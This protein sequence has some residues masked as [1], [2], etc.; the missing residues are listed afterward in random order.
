MIKRNL[1]LRSLDGQRNN[2]MEL[3][4]A[5]LIQTESL[6]PSCTDKE[7][8]GRSC[9][10]MYEQWDMPSCGEPYTEDRYFC[11]LSLATARCCD[12]FGLQ[13]NRLG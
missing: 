3:M 2:G 9:L 13:R 4:T 10:D 11:E 6:G 7:D 12:I 1:V 8:E 5:F